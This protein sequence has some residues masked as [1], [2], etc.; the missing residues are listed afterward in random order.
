[1]QPL[2][3]RTNPEDVGLKEILE[4]ILGGVIVIEPSDRLLLMMTDLK[5]LATRVVVAPE[6]RRRPFIIPRV[7]AD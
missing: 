6:R 3:L 1:V 5:T 7:K 2:H 4:R